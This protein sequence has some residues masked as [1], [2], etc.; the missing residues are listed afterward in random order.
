MTLTGIELNDSVGILKLNNGITNP[1]D[2]GF[3]NEILDNLDNLKNDP[4]V[5]SL[6]LTSGN[7]KFFSIGFNLPVLIDQSRDEV[8]TFFSTFNRLCMDLF[9]FP[10]PTLAAIPGHAV[11]GGCILTLCCDQRFIA[12]GHKLMGLNEIKLGVSIPYPG[13]CMLQQIT[14]IQNAGKIME[15]GDFYEPPESL[16]MGLLD[17]V[18]PLEDLLPRSIAKAKEM[19][20]LP[21]EV[22]GLIKNERTRLV[23]DLVQ[24]NLAMK[25]EKFIKCWFLDDTR[26]RL[27]EAAKKF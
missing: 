11:A 21:A 16:E 25:E 20:E 13:A 19:G 8:T 15:L 27:R 1:L 18:I 23:Q 22:Y 3:L 10:K 6:V 5:A 14:G 26:G 24:A 9:T 17:Q 2:L 7:N 4:N 12:D